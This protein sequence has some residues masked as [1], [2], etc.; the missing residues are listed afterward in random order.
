MSDFVTVGKASNL[1]EGGFLVAEVGGQNVVVAH[2][3]G[4]FYAIAEECTHSGG[5]LGDGTLD[6]CEIEC[7]WHGSRFDVRTGE[8]T[9]PPA[10]SPV[11]TYSV[12]IEGDDILV[13]L[14]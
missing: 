13:G 11:A 8:V 1:P 5:P 2:A 7:P 6:G 14:G 9:M 4:E 10:M 3:E 12:K